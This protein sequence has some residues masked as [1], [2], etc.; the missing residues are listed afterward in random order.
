METELKETKEELLQE[1]KKCEVALKLNRKMQKQY[2]RAISELKEERDAKNDE[3]Q[4]LLDKARE[5]KVLR[6]S[7][8]REFQQLKEK[9][10]KIHEEI[11]EL[12][13]QR[14]S[15]WIL[16]KEFKNEF[17]NLLTEKRELK[18]DSVESNKI[19]SEILKLDW[20][21]QTTSM[22]LDQ[23]KKLVERIERLNSKINKNTK[24]K[25]LKMI[26]LELNELIRNLDEFRESANHYHQL[27]T[28][29]YPKTE[30]L[31][32]RMNDVY[33]LADV[34]HEKMKKYYDEIDEIKAVAD[35]CHDKMVEKIKA[36]R[37]LRKGY[38]S[39]EKEIEILKHKLGKIKFRERQIRKNKYLRFKEDKAQEL[40]ERH[41]ANEQLTFDE[42]GYLLNRGLISIDEIDKNDS[43]KNEIE[44]NDSKYKLTNIK[45]LGV[46]D[47][48]VLVENGI[49]TINDLSDCDI[50]KLI[51]II[52]FKSSI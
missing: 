51:E 7:Y 37:L 10:D 36:V 2:D 34:H 48:K 32:E 26:N 43:N 20:K 52:P 47:E 16:Y 42:I 4:G 35:E 41:R 27:I 6:D 1:L 9:K 38:D 31:Q 45:G 11:A 22:D 18:K 3:F 5:E 50:E 8:N 46:R 29:L 15:K 28:E 14:D 39:K 40:L 24:Y 12:K 21:I 19:I 30:D 17:H 33:K 44:L 23:E 49:N 13:A 25:K